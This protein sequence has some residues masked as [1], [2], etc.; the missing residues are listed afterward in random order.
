[1]KINDRMRYPHPVLSE[2]SSD[3]S[4]GELTA[5]FTHQTTKDGQLCLIAD[6]KLSSDD[7]TK[8]IADQR[9]AVGYFIVCNQTYFNKLQSASVGAS[10]SFFNIDQLHGSV[11][12]RPVIWTLREIENFSSPLI[13]AEFGDDIVI[14]KGSIIA[15]GPEFRMSLDPRRF[16]PFE[17]IFEIA[18]SDEVDPGAIEV[19]TDREKITIFAE[20]KTYAGIVNMRN[21]GQGRM[22][23]LNAVYMPAV[24]DV[25]ARLQT[26]DKSVT[27][28]HWYRVFAAKC[29]EVGINPAD[30]SASP[31]AMAQRLLREP[32]KGTIKVM[33]SA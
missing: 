2:F 15:M 20:P 11:T 23:L 3:Y 4:T 18:Q 13:D 33:E 9:A 6:L 22:V 10:E 5:S 17:S 12:L 14:R 1:V 26:G 16:K 31:L 28:R 27:S 32:L 19:D 7:L 30:Q 24:M 21:I 25:I 8:L 29:D